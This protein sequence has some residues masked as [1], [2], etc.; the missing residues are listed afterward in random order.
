MMTA[1]E[2]VAALQ[3]NGFDAAWEN[4]GG[5]VMNVDVPV[6]DAAGVDVGWVA[7]SHW[8]EW[9]SFDF[10]MGCGEVTVIAYDMA[11]G[12]ALPVVLWH[13]AAADR[14]EV[15]GDYALA[16]DAGTVVERVRAAVACVTAHGSPIG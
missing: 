11:T 5:G 10:D 13:P 7:V 6:T 3:S 12:D 9:S 2:I 14:F 15:P 8:G 1:R 4:T 16:T